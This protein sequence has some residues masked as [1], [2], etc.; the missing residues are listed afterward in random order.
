MPDADLS[1]GTSDR[2]RSLSNGTSS[3]ARSTRCSS[4]RGQPFTRS[5]LTR[6]GAWRAVSPKRGPVAGPGS[7]NGAMAAAHRCCQFRQLAPDLRGRLPRPGGFGE[8]VL[9]RY[10]RRAETDGKRAR[11][12]SAAASFTRRDPGGCAR[13][14]K[15]PQRD[16]RR[17]PGWVRWN[18]AI[19]L[20]PARRGFSQGQSL[21]CFYRLPIWAN[22]LR[23][24]VWTRHLNR[25]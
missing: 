15:R 21:C 25:A 4:S 12:K 24:T 1:I 9:V 11:L 7:E 13:P 23:K 6:G 2:A 16:P 17:G 19:L 8:K 10:F 14:R 20:I 5:D 22:S 3:S 18:R